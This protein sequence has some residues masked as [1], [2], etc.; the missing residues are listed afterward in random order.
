ML[1]LHH[2]AVLNIVMI[3]NASICNGVAQAGRTQTFH[4]KYDWYG[5]GFSAVLKAVIFSFREGNIPFK[6][7]W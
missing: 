3:Q 5:K 6:K 1:T 7:N 4:S 2:R